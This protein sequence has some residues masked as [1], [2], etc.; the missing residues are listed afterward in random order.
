MSKLEDATRIWVDIDWE[1][2]TN[3]LLR[4]LIIFQWKSNENDLV[5][6]I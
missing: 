6:T 4:A 3:E 1:N 2:V 5:I